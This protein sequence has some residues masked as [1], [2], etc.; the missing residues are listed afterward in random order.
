[1]LLLN[2]WTVMWN[3]MIHEHEIKNLSNF[4]ILVNWS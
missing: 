1:M 4:V 3:Q 2:T